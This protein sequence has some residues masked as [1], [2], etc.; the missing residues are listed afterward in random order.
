MSGAT[1]ASVGTDVV[2]NIANVWLQLEGMKQQKRESKR[3]ERLQFELYEGQK[4]EEKRTRIE[5]KEW[6]REQRRYENMQTF[7]DRITGLFNRRPQYVSQLIQ[8]QKARQ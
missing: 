3:V 8:M 4:R 7:L 2:G 5:E 6:A 1:W